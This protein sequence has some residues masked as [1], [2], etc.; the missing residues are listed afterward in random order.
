MFFLRFHPKIGRT[1]PEK[2]EPQVAESGFNSPS[3]A[4]RGPYKACFRV[5]VHNRPVPPR[6][7]EVRLQHRASARCVAAV[8][9]QNP[10]VPTQNLKKIKLPKVAPISILKHSWAVL[11]CIHAPPREIGSRRPV[12]AKLAQNNALQQAKK[13]IFGVSLVLGV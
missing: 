6:V 7:G 10:A 3:A 8:P 1:A 12:P 2:F 13:V 9:C 4:F 5:I 11:E